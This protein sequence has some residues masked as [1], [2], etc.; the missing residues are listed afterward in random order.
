MAKTMRGTLAIERVKSGPQEGEYFWN[1]TLQLFGKEIN[2]ISCWPQ[3][4]KKKVDCIKNAELVL[5][6]KWIIDND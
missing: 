5:M 3:A 2:V 1:L 4:Y 6:N